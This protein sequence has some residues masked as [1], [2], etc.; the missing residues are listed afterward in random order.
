MRFLGPSPHHAKGFGFSLK[1]YQM[2]SIHTRPEK[3]NNATI[4]DHFEFVFEENSVREI[5]CL[6]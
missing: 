2:F 3:S 4:I 5:T 1:T 6:A